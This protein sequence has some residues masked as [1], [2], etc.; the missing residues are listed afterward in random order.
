M[1][2]KKKRNVKTSLFEGNT[3]LN[4]LNFKENDFL[5]PANKKRLLGVFI[6][7]SIFF[8]PYQE[9]WDAKENFRYKQIVHFTE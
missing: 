4:K 2:L 6:I 3:E 1:N 5:P 9:I 7:H 8:C